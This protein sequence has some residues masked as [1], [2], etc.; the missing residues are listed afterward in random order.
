V[1][2]GGEV[3]SDAGVSGLPRDGTHQDEIRNEGKG[4]LQTTEDAQHLKSE[5]TGGNNPNKAFQTQQVKSTHKQHDII[6]L[7]IS[8]NS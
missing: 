6:F 7:S 8:R 2:P 4:D 1:L 3:A 5:S